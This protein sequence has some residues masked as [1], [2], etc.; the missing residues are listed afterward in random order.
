MGGSVAF[1]PMEHLGLLFEVLLGVF[2]EFGF[3]GSTDG[4]YVP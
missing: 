2:E 1:E 3:E 4:V